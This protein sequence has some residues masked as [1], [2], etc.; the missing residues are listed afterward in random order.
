[1]REPENEFL[2]GQEENDSK[3]KSKEIFCL[4]WDIF[5]NGSF[6]EQLNSWYQNTRN[7]LL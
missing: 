7:F 4:F 2:I 6:P 3:N 1:M 5:L